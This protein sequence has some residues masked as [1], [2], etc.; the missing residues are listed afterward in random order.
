MQH[1]YHPRPLLGHDLTYLRSSLKLTYAGQ[2]VLVS[3]RLDERNTMVPILCL[4]SS[5]QKLY[6]LL[7]SKHLILMTSGDLNIDLTRK[8]FF[9]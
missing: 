4:L 2:P 7:F 9:L 6:R 1:D 5:I 3:N 8:C